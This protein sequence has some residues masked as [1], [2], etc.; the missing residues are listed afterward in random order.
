MTEA[1]SLELITSMINDSRSR[2]ARNSGTPFLIWGYTLIAMFITK[3]ILLLNLTGDLKLFAF[4]SIPIF[5][6]PLIAFILSKIIIK[7]RNAISNGS[8]GIRRLWIVIG[9]ITII[10][11]LTTSSHLLTMAW[12]LAIGVV[13]TGV[14]TKEHCVTS[15][16]IAGIIT[17]ILL[18]FF[19]LFALPRIFSPETWTNE[20]DLGFF[21]IMPLGFIM[22]ST[23]VIMIII[24]TILFIV[25]GHMLNHKYNKTESEC[26][27]S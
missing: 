6:T 4:S 19:N 10:V 7:D 20:I 1:Q 9:I 25:P 17:S 21:T 12:L 5:L 13:A 16:G 3:I 14:I 22:I 18:P 23:S 8:K 26:S 15:C 27:K 24:L 2:L 11:M